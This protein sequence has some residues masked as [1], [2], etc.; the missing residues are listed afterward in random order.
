M[1]NRKTI[2]ARDW[3]TVQI[4]TILW[5]LVCEHLDK[6]WRVRESV[7]A[8]FQSGH[9]WTQKVSEWALFWFAVTVLVLQACKEMSAE[10]KKTDTKWN[11][12]TIFGTISQKHVGLLG[13]CQ[14]FRQCPYYLICTSVL[15]CSARQTVSNAFCNRW[16]TQ[17]LFL[18]ASLRAFRSFCWV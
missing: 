13:Y 3:C 18:S 8:T 4:I 2:E 7:L 11:S 6:L 1:T 15:H 10:S 5:K 14:N 12:S 9:Q 16:N 17:S